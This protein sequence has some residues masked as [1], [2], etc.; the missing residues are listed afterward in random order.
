MRPIIRVEQA[1]RSRNCC[2]C[3]EKIDRGGICI[4][5]RAYNISINLCMECFYKMKNIAQ[6]GNDV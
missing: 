1:L 2:Q 6:R 5:F 3:N 4:K